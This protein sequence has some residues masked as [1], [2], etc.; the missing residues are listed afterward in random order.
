MRNWLVAIRERNL[1]T[2]QEVAEHVGVTRQ[3]ISAIENEVVNPSVTVAK[4]IAEVLGF[5][6][7]DFFETNS[8]RG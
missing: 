4:S 8:K 3:T 6:W 5:N 1:L 2:Q 7:T